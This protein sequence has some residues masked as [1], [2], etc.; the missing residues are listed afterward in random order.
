MSPPKRSR[1]GSNQGGQIELAAE[2]T[3]AAQTLAEARALA[4]KLDQG[5][6]GKGGEA[7]AILDAAAA[8]P[9]GPA[10]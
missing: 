2:A 1:A 6:A 4:A 7:L 8:K 3:R 10:R 9:P 5:A